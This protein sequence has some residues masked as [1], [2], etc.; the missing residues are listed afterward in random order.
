[1]V[2]ELK[3]SEDGGHMELQAIRYAAMVSALTFDQVL[4]IFGR[5][6][7]SVKRD[8][9]PKEKILDF[10]EWDEP[11]KESFAQEVNQYINFIACNLVNGIIIHVWLPG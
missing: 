6:L 10:L 3:R 8:D 2:I 4:E 11:D 5:F 9:D 1:M 7:E